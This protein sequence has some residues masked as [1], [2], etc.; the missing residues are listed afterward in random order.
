[1]KTSAPKLRGGGFFVLTANEHKIRSP[2][3]TQMYADINLKVNVL[4]AYICVICGQNKGSASAGKFWLNG[5]DKKR[6]VV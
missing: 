2:Q 3:I 1:L 5:M 4:S 6:G